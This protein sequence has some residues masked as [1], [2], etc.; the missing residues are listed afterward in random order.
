MRPA[1]TG[2]A[3]FLASSRE[4]LMADLYTFALTHGEV[5]RYSG[6][7]VPFTVPAGYFPPQSLNAAAGGT[8]ILGPRFGRTLVTTKIGVQTDTV[9]IEIFAGANDLIGN[10]TWQNAFRLG[11]FDGAKIEVSRLVCLPP[12]G[13]GIG[14]LVGAIVWFQGYVGEVQIGRSM[15][16]VTANSML[17]YLNVQYPRRLWQHD[18]TH[19]FGDTMCQFDR[20]SMAVLVVAQINSTQS[21]ISTGFNPTPATLYDQGTMIGN[22]GQ[23]TGFKRGIASANTGGIAFLTVP[24]LYP[25]A[26]GD[27]FTMLPGCDHSIATC[28]NTFNNLAHHGGFPYIPPPEYAV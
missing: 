12:A 9:P 8:F 28:Q 10:L 7:S 24:F 2:L 18:C 4:F 19:V 3:S 5:L 21:Q 14:A 13:V 27:T 25:V 1:P 6:Y 22:S 15:I 26:V 23:N 11:V 17:G 16:T 20:N